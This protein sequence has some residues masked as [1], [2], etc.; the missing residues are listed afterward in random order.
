R[1][2]LR[3]IFNELGLTYIIKDEMI[4]VVTASRAKDMMV[5][6]R[7]YVGDLLAGMADTTQLTTPVP[8]SGLPGVSGLP[9]IPGNAQFQ[10]WTVLP[11]G[12][13]P[14]CMYLRTQL[15]TI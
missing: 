4:Q 1:N 6:R 11:T 14:T 8:A 15:H 9:G 5:V 12:G 10:P 13:V 7:Y 3:K 2:V